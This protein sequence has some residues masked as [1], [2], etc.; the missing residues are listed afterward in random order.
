[1]ENQ[2]KWLIYFI[3][4]ITLAQW[5]FLGLGAMTFLFV[6]LMY[7]HYEKSTQSN[8]RKEERRREL[9]KSSSKD[10]GRKP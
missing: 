8:F 1:L 7:S 2:R 6:R 9:S 5:F 3:E 10:L 4:S